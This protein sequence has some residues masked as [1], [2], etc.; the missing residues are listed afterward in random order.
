MRGGRLITGP[1][2][3]IAPLVTGDRIGTMRLLGPKGHSTAGKPLWQAECEACGETGVYFARRLIGRR[4]AGHPGCFKCFDV[5]YKEGRP[6]PAMRR[7]D[8]EESRLAERT[9]NVVC[10]VCF[11]LPHVRV[12]GKPCAC[13]RWRGELKAPRELPSLRSVIC[14]ECST[15]RP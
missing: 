8:Q 2:T 1:K 3:G 13:G 4:E 11:G 5:R 15:G 14:L 12:A 7:R 6:R 10:K 9:P